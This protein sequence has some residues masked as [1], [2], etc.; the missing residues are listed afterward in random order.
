MPGNT[1]AKIFFFG[2][3]LFFVLNCISVVRADTFPQPT[4]APPPIAKGPITG[5][6]N[7]VSII[8]NVLLYFSAVFWIAAAG[9][10]FYAAYLYL[11]AAGNEERVKKAKN[12][13]LYAVIAMVIGLMAEGA[14]YLICAFLSLGG[15]SC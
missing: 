7:I 9:F 1:F 8:N 13:L 4:P 2:F 11:T 10:V 15:G 3:L 12:Q 6:G 5:P 14:P